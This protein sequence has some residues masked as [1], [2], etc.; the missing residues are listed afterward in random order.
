ML[1]RRYGNKI[2]AIMVGLVLT[3]MFVFDSSCGTR[4]EARSYFVTL[5]FNR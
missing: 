3:V 5:V 2:S 4:G 1:P